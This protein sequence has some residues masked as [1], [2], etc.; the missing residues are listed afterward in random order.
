MLHSNQ[1]SKSLADDSNHFEALYHILNGQQTSRS[2]DPFQKP[3]VTTTL[4]SLP[5]FAALANEISVKT[6]DE[7][8]HCGTKLPSAF[9][10]PR[11]VSI[12][13][14]RLTYSALDGTNLSGIEQ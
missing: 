6:E 4:G 1:N 10:E 7:R 12:L 2:F 5:T 14:I 9:C 8:R 13:N 3:K 11:S